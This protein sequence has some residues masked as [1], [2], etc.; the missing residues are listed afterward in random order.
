MPPGSGQRTQTF[1]QQRTLLADH[2]Q[3]QNVT[4]A[5]LA[6]MIGRSAKHVNQVL[7]GNAG[8]HELDYWAWVLGLEFHVTLTAR[9]GA[10]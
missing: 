3:A 5:D 7:N 1:T 6:R 2:M 10:P 9:D 4:Q 8:T